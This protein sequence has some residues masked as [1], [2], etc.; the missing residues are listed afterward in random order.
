MRKL[1]ISK[2]KDL[3]LSDGKPFFYFADTVWS[4]FTNITFEDWEEYLEKRKSQGFNTLQIDILPQWDRCLPDLNI[5]PFEIDANGKYIY[6]SF[7]EAYFDRAEKMLEIAVKFG[8]T[9][10]LI[11]LWSNYVP[12]THFKGLYGY[13]PMP[14]SFV[15]NYCKYIV[16]RFAKF[17][18]IFAI[19]G[20]TNFFKTADEYY[21][22]AL[23]TIKKEAPDCLTTLHICGGAEDIIPLY[24]AVDYPDLLMNAPELDFYMYQSGHFGDYFD[25]SFNYCKYF[26]DLPVKR[27]II[28]SEPCYEGW[29]NGVEKYTGLHVRKVTYLSLLAG[30]KAGIT[31][32]GQGI[33]Q[34]QE[35]SKK[36]P[37]SDPSITEKLY[38]AKDPDTWREVLNYDG[39]YEMCYAKWLFESFGLYDI[40][41]L[42]VDNGLRHFKMAASPEQK[43]VVMYVPV[44]VEFEV[45]MNF[46]EYEVNMIILDRKLILKPKMEMKNGTTTFKNYPFLSDAIIICIQ[47]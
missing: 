23:V 29:S 40:E 14:F 34:W 17:N 32:G 45:P 39:V 21:Y 26:Y 44:G 12:D 41:P 13:D 18:P 4:A 5:H 1:T 35:K 7:N 16:K 22:K 30:A 2:S 38:W 33:W 27:P 28:N 15:E 47:K 31:Y 19:S 8:F 3:I 42:E 9:P 6:E 43:K 10:A 24:H 46:S 25:R 37:P 20:D 11:V 36:H